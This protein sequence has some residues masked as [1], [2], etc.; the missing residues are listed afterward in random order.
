MSSSASFITGS[1]LPSRMSL[2]P[3]RITTI[4]GDC[5]TTLV[6][7][8]AS[9]ST[10]VSPATPLL[11]ARGY[12]RPG[13]DRQKLGAD[14]QQKG[15]LSPKK[16]PFLFRPAATAAHDASSRTRTSPEMN[17]PRLIELAGGIVP[18]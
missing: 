5:A 4:S 16:T 15:E 8:R 12:G 6:T 18:M 17:F 9:M 10:S 11:I 1:E 13:G 3:P 14:D 2:C 7:K